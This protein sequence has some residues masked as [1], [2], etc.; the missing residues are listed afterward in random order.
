MWGIING[1]HSLN[2]FVGTSLAAN[3]GQV[4]GDQESSVYTAR[5]LVTG[6]PV[7]RLKNAADLRGAGRRRH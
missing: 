7:I 1:L 6:V 4:D 3:P 2:G 5:R